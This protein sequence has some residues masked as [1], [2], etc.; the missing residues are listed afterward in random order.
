MI[1]RPTHRAAALGATL[2]LLLALAVT[3]ASPA[4]AATTATF[5]TTSTW[6]TGYTGAY[7][8]ANTGPGTTTGWRIDFDLP[9]TTT[10]GTFWDAL[11]TRTGNHYTFTNRDYN[12]TITP[13]ATAGFGFTAA[14]TASPTNCTLNGTPCTGGGGGTTTTTRP[15]TTT[16]TTRPT[17][18]TSPPTT[19][20]PPGPGAMA[21]APYLYYGWGNPPS[22]AQVMQ[23]T[24]VRWFTLAFILS[25]GGCN[26]AWDGTR[27]LNGSDATRISEIRAA[28]GNVIPSVGGWAGNK[29]GERCT[30]ANAL[31]DAYQ[32]VIN[33]YGLR[34]IDVDIE[35]T[36]FENDAAQQ[37]VIDALKLVESR[38]PGIATYVTFPTL[39][40]GPNW[41]GQQLILKG[42]RAGYRPDGWVIMP[43]DF[44]GGSDMGAASIQAAEGLKAQLK[45][46]YGIGD[47]EAYRMMGMSSMN[48]RTDIAEIVTQAHFQAMLN[49]ANQHHLARFTFWSVNRDR[50]CTAG[51]DASACSGI[52]QQPWDFTRIVAQYRG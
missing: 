25:D 4:S 19:N 39:T 1:G 18:T 9:A 2:L 29:L 13:G 27:P 38:N 23:A 46:A 45:S 36:E 31:A 16:T 44:G 33:A 41:W 17:T 3:L 10:I 40:T 43:F 42:A 48:G 28:G 35:A 47:A 8:I 30:S 24:G 37:R 51:G 5:T 7:T 32:R 20:P 21:A 34:A 12:A 52:S 15:G 11:L 26:P 14:G 49:Y 50:P 22:A 6:E